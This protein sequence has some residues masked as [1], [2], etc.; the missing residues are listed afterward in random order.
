M[1]KYQCGQVLP[2]GLAL[3][4][5]GLV[6]ALTIYNTGVAATDKMRLANSA[7]AA[8]YSAA[9]WQARALNYQ[10]YANRAMVANQVAIGQ[11]V[12]LKSWITYAA[13][14]GE[15]LATATKAVPF[16][17]VVTGGIQVA[18]SVA[19]VGVSAAAD[20]MLLAAN[21]AT[22]ALSLSQDA[23]NAATLYNTSE[24]ISVVARETDGRFT[25]N[26]VYGLT[27]KGL[28]AIDWLAFNSRYTATDREAMKE[29]Q[30]IILASSDDFTRARN[31]DL[32][33]FWIP[34][35]FI[36]FHKL[37]RQGE[38]TL[39]AVD[40]DAGMEWEWMAKDTLSFHTK[41]LGFFGSDTLELPVGWASAFANSRNDSKPLVAQG[42]NSCERYTKNNHDAERLADRNVNS[43]A[44]R[45]TLKPMRGYGGVRSFWVLSDRARN[46]EDARLTIRVEVTLPAQKIS[47]S[48]TLINA[49][50]L[51]AP[52]VVAGNVMSSISAADVFY[53]HP[54]H[55]EA[56]ASRQAK[57]NLYNPYWQAQ[58]SPVNAIERNAVI[59][60]RAEGASPTSVARQ[61]NNTKGLGQ[62][63]NSS[64]LDTGE[65]Q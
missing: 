51:D 63:Q 4:V 44:G 3:V 39:V 48:N 41:T 10:A 15:N 1:K 37:R 35:S 16:L 56:P 65:K 40:T 29:R 43:L 24:I 59:L 27:N 45:Q 18:T 62:Y 22:L 36:T 60:T 64:T 42:C 6:G 14:T 17:N 55:Y 11:A 57:A 61:S 54:Q 50:N 33:D 47:E 8:A 25:T 30:E 13:V 2:L 38:T 19:E 5:F 9:L 53:K 23:I 34:S 46:A 52:I 49:E 20:V 31:W 26:S 7:D 32:F 12:S 28:N 58:L 21:A